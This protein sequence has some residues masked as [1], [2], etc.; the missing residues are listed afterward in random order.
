MLERSGF[1]DVYWTGESKYVFGNGIH[2]M[3]TARMG[4][5]SKDINT[6]WK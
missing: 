6:K 1:K 5:D 4:H 2:E 3:G